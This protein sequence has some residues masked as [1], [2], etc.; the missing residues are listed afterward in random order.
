MLRGFSIQ[1][2]KHDNA[3]DPLHFTLRGESFFGHLV[4]PPTV[5][6]LHFWV[7]ATQV[8]RRDERLP[9]GDGAYVSIEE[10]YARQQQLLEGRH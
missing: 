9:S 7:P 6:A 8:D 2:I 5:N 4:A 1:K 3:K 10:E